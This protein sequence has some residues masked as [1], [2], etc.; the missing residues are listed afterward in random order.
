MENSIEYIEKR[1][2]LPGGSQMVFTEQAEQHG[3]MRSVLWQQLGQRYGGERV[4]GSAG[5]VRE[6][7]RLVWEGRLG[8]HGKEF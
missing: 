2:D 1:T 5:G 4:F 6:F 7:R 8:L 3:E